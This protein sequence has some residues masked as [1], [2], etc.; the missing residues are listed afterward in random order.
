[1]AIRV[2]NSETWRK[3]GQPDVGSKMFYINQKTGK[4]VY[5][6]VVMVNFGHKKG[7]QL[8]IKPNKK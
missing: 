6:T 2:F 8:K 4:K 7:V 5:G 1:M 3:I